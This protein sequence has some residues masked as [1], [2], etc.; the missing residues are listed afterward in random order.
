ML[1]VSLKR[2]IAPSLWQ[3]VSGLDLPQNSW[4]QD[5]VITHHKIALCYLEEAMGFV[6]RVERC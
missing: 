5:E 2:E 3:H 4:Q 6:D 1:R